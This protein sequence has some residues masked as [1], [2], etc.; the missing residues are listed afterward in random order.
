[1]Y[2]GKKKRIEIERELIREKKIMMID[3]EK[4]EID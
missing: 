2:G 4:Y 1:M 3:E